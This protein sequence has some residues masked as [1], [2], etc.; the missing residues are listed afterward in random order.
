MDKYSY[1]FTIASLNVSVM[2]LVAAGIILVFQK[3][4]ATALIPYL[5][6]ILTLLGGL[7]VSPPKQQYDHRQG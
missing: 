2:M 4:N 6:P 7:L 5:A 3:E 1:R